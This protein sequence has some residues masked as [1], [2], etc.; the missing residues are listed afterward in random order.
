MSTGNSCSVCFV[1][2]WLRRDKQ[3]LTYMTLIEEN[4]INFVFH[5]TRSKS[6][7][8]WS[9]THTHRLPTQLRVAV[10]LTTTGNSAIAGILLQRGNTR[11]KSQYNHKHQHV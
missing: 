9:T 8:N 11:R 5:W 6:G 1:G 3:R 2:Y 7:Y 10:Q 4:N